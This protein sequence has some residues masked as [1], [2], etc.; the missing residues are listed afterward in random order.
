MAF[1][2]SETHVLVKKNA[3]EALGAHPQPIDSFLV[4][5]LDH[6]NT[7]LDWVIS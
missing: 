4:I 7:H 6:T 5:D 2:A 3:K 1:E